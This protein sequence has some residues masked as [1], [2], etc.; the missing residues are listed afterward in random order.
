MWIEDAWQ[1]KLQRIGDES[2]MEH[3]SQIPKI[4]KV[5]LKLANSIRL[6]LRVV[7]IADLTDPQGISIR[8]GMLTGD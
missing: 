4:T 6:Y 7:T 2:I 8:D 3:F 1:P 5:Q